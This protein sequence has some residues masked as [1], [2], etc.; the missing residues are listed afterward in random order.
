MINNFFIASFATFPA[1]F[2]TRGKVSSQLNKL[3]SNKIH[4]IRESKGVKLL[5]I[6]R[7][8]SLS[9]SAYSRI[10]KGETQITVD[11]LYKIAEALNVQ[12]QELLPLSHEKL[13]Q[14]NN[15]FVTIS[16]TEE[17]VKA[18]IESITDKL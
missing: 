6:A 2:R 10:E 1:N 9:P 18:L 14:E 4:Q 11:N 7:A 17:Q 8:V 13:Q 5:T 3:I 15:S 16:L 12:V